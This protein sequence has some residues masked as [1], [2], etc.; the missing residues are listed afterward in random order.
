MIKADDWQNFI[1]LVASADEITV[2]KP[3]TEDALSLMFHVLSDLDYEAVS[4]AVLQH[5]QS[6]KW[7]I[8]PADIRAK[9]LGTD[10]EKSLLAWHIFIEALDRY[11]PYES[12]RFKDPAIHSVIRALGGA[13]GWVEVTRLYVEKDDKE[14]SFWQKEFR[15]TYETSAR[16]ATWENV[17]A[18]F[19]G[20]YEKENQ[21]IEL[22]E[23]MFQTVVIVPGFEKV[24]L[25]Q[26]PIKGA[27]LPGSGS[28]ELK[29]IDAGQEEE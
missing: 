28:R 6:C 16:F 19:P 21:G 17:P 12:V 3:R 25:S 29:Q 5:V 14:L 23:G 13:G 22:P 24:P 15:E 20:H 7:A 2:G 4:N 18:Y 8:T 10:K 11:G 26:I 1:D 9:V 27:M